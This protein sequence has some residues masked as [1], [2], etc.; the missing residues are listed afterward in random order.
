MTPHSYP[1]STPVRPALLQF[2]IS[3]GLCLDDGLNPYLI[4]AFL[5]C[6]TCVLT[7]ALTDS[8]GPPVSETFPERSALESAERR[9]R[10][11]MPRTSSTQSC[12]T[13]RSTHTR[14]S[15]PRTLDCEDDASRSIIHFSLLAITLLHTLSIS[16]LIYYSTCNGVSSSCL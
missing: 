2:N 7:P 1:L 8:S 16:I 9:T 15:R 13:S 14:A 3:C 6:R 12:S 11:R 5:A 4:L 10:T